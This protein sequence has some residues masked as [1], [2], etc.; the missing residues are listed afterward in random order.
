MRK[1]LLHL[2]IA[3]YNMCMCNVEEKKICLTYFREYIFLSSETEIV[4]GF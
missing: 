3:K 2:D 4:G 1:K